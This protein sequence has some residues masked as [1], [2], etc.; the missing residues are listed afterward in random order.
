MTA[1]DA[2]DWL[3]VAVLFVGLAYIPFAGKDGFRSFLKDCRQQPVAMLGA[4][5]MWLGMLSFLGWMLSGG[6]VP[7]QGT[8]LLLPG[9][10]LVLL[11]RRVKRH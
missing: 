11:S 8:W 4:M 3:W 7:V 9:F 10:L 6:L 2:L 5:L 1:P